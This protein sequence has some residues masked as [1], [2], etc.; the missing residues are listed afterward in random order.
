MM[1]LLVG[2]KPYNAG[3]S[4]AT[5]GWTQ[6]TPSYTDGVV[7]AGVDVGSMQVSAWWK[8]ATADP[9]TN[10]TL[11]EGSPIWDV[12][13]AGVMVFSKG[14]G[15]TWDTPVHRGGGDANTSNP[16]TMTAPDNPGITAGDV[17]VG[18]A[19]ARSDGATPAAGTLLPNAPGITG[20]TSTRDPATDPETTTGGDMA[21]M[22]SRSTVDAGTATGPPGL[23]VSLAAAHT[24]SLMLIRLR[25]MAAP[26]S[27]VEDPMPYLNAG[28]YPEQG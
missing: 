7:A 10:P 20:W 27:A 13:G 24:G 6:L 23:N 8:E 17:I 26:P 21:L 3:I 12:Y 9:E 1:L 14:A 25:V 16:L 11:T 19:A 15:E 2:G 22:V 18:H 5:A 4:V 28:Y